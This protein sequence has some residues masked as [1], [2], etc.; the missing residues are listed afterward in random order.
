M[1]VALLQ[2][3]LLA[4]SITGIPYILSIN[5]ADNN[6]TDDGLGR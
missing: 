1:S 6:L 2:A 3:A 5:V 4:D